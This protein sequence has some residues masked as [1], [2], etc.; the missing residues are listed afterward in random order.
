MNEKNLLPSKP[1]YEVDF[2]IERVEAEHVSRREFAKFLCLVSGGMAVGSG[3]VAVKDR[4]FP[5]FRIR[6]EVFVCRTGDV[7]VGG[8]H[9]FQIEGTKMPYIL[10][11]PAEDEWYAYEQKCTHLSCAVFYSPKHGK[12]ECPCHNGW[13][14]PRTGAVLQGPPPRPLPRLT[15]VIKG[16]GIYVA[17]PRTV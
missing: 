8:T 5:P 16:G 9:P 6:G 10:I 3:W 7:V 14:D 17:E 11:R 12:I 4:L 2:P 1:A 15:V 13:F